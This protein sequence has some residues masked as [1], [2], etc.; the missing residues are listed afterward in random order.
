VTP[1]GGVSIFVPD[2]SIDIAHVDTDY[3]PSGNLGLTASAV[4][5]PGTWLMLALGLGLLAARSRQ[6]T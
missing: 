1:Y 4:P 2:H 3:V 6:R 5:E